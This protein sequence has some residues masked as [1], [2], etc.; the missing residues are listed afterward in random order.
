MP[1]QK[2]SQINSANLLQIVPYDVLLS[3]SVGYRIGARVVNGGGL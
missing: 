1:I 2:L 3:L